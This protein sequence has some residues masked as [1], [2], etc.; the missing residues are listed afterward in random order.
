MRKGRCLQLSLVAACLAPRL[1]AAQAPPGFEPPPPGPPPG[2]D[3]GAPVEWSA[4]LGKG[5]TARSADDTFALTL[6][7]RMQLQTAVT[8]PTD[9]AVDAGARDAVTTET[10]VRR[11]RVLF[12]GHA[13]TKQLQYYVQL[14][15]T[16]RDMEPDL[17]SPLRDAYVTYAARPW[18]QLRAGQTKVPFGRQRVVSSSAQQMVDR[19]LVVGELNLDR[20]VGVY[21]FSK[22][23]GGVFVYQL[24]VFSGDGRNRAIARPGQLYVGRVQLTP[25]GDFD[26]LTEGDH[27][28]SARPRLAVGVAGAW[29]D[30]TIRERSTFSDV[31]TLGDFDYAHFAADLV[32]KVAG[33]SLQGELLLRQADRDVLPAPDPADDE[34]SRS[35]LGA[36]GQV[37][38]LIDEH[39]EVSARYGHLRPRG[40]TA[41]DLVE[42]NELG[43]GVSYYFHQHALKLQADYF[44]IFGPS[45]EH[46]RH[47]ARVQLQ[48]YY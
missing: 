44:H 3:H 9:D 11:M 45:D 18:L 41:P 7:L 19:S 46:D 47:L 12:Q 27:E 31:Y 14:A 39:L 23:L 42:I 26:D 22:P 34:R 40:D 38:Y 29:N 24:G 32:F 28:R 13:F 16:N 8:A 30:N 5:I 25:L 43:G 20:D 15:F 35:A 1:S 2:A 17:R 6:R 4:R 10:A 21:L 36:Y 33:F 37:G 48:V